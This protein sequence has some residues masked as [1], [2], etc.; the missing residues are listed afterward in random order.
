MKNRKNACVKSRPIS[1]TASILSASEFEALSARYGAG[2]AQQIADEM[3]VAQAGPATPQARPIDYFDIKQLNDL[4]AEYRTRLRGLVSTCRKIRSTAAQG[5]TLMR[6][7]Y[8]GHEAQFMNRQMADMWQLYRMAQADSHT[9]TTE[10]LNRLQADAM[11]VMPEDKAAAKTAQT[12]T[13]ARK[14]AA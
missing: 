7:V 14:R 2:F 6:R 8:A 13:T 4:A 1:N 3:A 12:K 9:L 5:G 11:F 10:Y